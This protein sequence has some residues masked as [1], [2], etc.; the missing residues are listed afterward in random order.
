MSTILRVVIV[1]VRLAF[2]S[3]LVI[4]GWLLVE[5]MGIESGAVLF[6]L[7][8]LSPLAWSSALWTFITL[9]LFNSRRH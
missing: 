7:L 1:L 4:V 3:T 9:G 8:L 6:F 2:L 5:D